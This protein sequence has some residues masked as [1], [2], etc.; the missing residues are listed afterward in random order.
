MTPTDG[1]LIPVAYNH[2]HSLRVNRLYTNSHE[3]HP[4]F[5]TLLSFTRSHNLVRAKQCNSDLHNT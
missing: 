5:V 2:M 1:Y 4:Y 3:R